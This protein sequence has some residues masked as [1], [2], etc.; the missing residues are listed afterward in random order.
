MFLSISKPRKSGHAARWTLLSSP[1]RAVS[2]LHASSAVNGSIGA[3]IL[4]KAEHLAERGCLD[5]AVETYNEGLS[6]LPHDGLL[7]LRMARTQASR[8][9][10]AEA[11]KALVEEME[12]RLDDFVYPLSLGEV[13]Y[14]SGDLPQALRA[15][16]AASRLDPSN[17]LI[18]AYL[19]LT[20]MGLGDV[21]EG[22]PEV[23]DRVGVVN[24]G[25][26]GRVLLYCETYLS[27]HLDTCRPLEQQVAAGE[28]AAR[29]QGFLGRMADLVERGVSRVWH[30][31]AG[32]MAAVRYLGRPRT[33]RARLSFLN[34]SLRYD[35]EEYDAS[36]AAF[37]TSLE[38][39][40]ER[41]LTRLRLADLCLQAGDYSG[42]LEWLG[43]DGE[44]TGAR[45]PAIL[46]VQG[47]ALCLDG[48]YA[49]ALERLQ[50]LASLQPR[51]Y[52]APY[53][54]GICHLRLG[55]RPRARD[56][57]ERAAGLRNPGIVRLRLEEMMRVRGLA[58]D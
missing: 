14:D 56:W 54:A 16:R 24:P 32:V 9:L 45:G 29:S 13:Y 11:R 50:A 33:R 28:R 12:R 51:E 4:T 1:Q 40:P 48:R 23:L 21:D 39:E 57:F 31:C 27:E 6:H 25:C 5:E 38:L 19:G 42:A 2:L 52:L 20:A 8:G 49:E 17:E 55:D 46:E 43:E 47:L 15:F 37:S 53:C 44:G 10:L 3:I 30:A 22:Y 58:S 18:K 41:R 34:G 26:Q 36:R 35:L 7:T